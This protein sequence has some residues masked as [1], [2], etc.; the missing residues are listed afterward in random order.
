MNMISKSNMLTTF[1]EKIHSKYVSEEDVWDAKRVVCILL[2]CVKC[3]SSSQYE[4]VIP[5][6]YGTQKNNETVTSGYYFY[7]QL[8]SALGTFRDDIDWETINEKDFLN[9]MVDEK[10]S[11]NKKKKVID[12]LGYLSSGNQRKLSEC[13]VL[14]LHSRI[15]MIKML[16]KYVNATNEYARIVWDSYYSFS[17]AESI[18]YEYTKKSEVSIMQSVETAIS[19][20]ELLLGDAYD[21]P[22][23]TSY[24]ISKKDYPTISDKK[25]NELIYEES[26]S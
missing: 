10:F 26:Y 25:L 7:N 4:I 1:W 21:E 23:P 20:I 6:E 8:I 12:L 24:L 17:P 2:R 14:D 13:T 19:I 16:I 5:K 11:M 9:Y 18:I 3:N 15:E 22:I